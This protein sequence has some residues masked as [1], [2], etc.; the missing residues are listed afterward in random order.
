[1]NKQEALKRAIDD[2]KQLVIYFDVTRPQYEKAYFRDGKFSLDKLIGQ[3]K[4]LDGWNRKSRSDRKSL[5]KVYSTYSGTFNLTF[6]IP[7]ELISS[8]IGS[9]RDDDG[10]KHRILFG[11]V[12]E[13]L[14]E[15][16]YIKVVN[17]GKKFSKDDD[18]NYKVKCWWNK[19][20]LLK[21]EK[22]WFKLFSEPKYSRIETFANKRVRKIV[23]NWISRFKKENQ[24]V[25][26]TVVE[27]TVVKPT[28]VEPTNVEPTVVEPEKIISETIKDNQDMD[29]NQ[30]KTISFRVIKSLLMWGI[31]SPETSVKWMSDFV[32][33]RRE[34]P[35]TI[36]EASRLY[37]TEP[38][39]DDDDKNAF[40]DKALD[41]F[42][43]NGF[44][45]SGGLHVLVRSLKKD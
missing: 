19:K 4:F 45:E 32:Y 22:H 31:I 30:K 28:N 33:R 7:R 1:M 37:N 6:G 35:F 25:E 42:K 16:N 15:Q 29:V 17:D 5:A 2:F 11:E 26:P 14:V 21:N 8:I 36:D 20:Y 13:P 27:P 10:K 40:V 44:P 24:K 12:I 3:Q 43:Q 41:Y 34:N 9:Y 18:G 23:F 39:D 38:V